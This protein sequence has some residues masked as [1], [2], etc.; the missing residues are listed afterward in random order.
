MHLLDQIFVVLWVFMALIAVIGG[1]LWLSNKKSGSYRNIFLGGSFGVLM[2]VAAYLTGT[3]S[4][5]V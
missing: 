3:F 4:I 5:S 2:C 1:G